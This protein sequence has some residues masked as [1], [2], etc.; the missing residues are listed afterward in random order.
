MAAVSAK[1]HHIDLSDNFLDFD[2]GRAFAAFLAENRTLEVLRVNNC[3]LGLKATEQIVEALTK[4]HEL[5]LR[6]FQAADND[7]CEE[8]MK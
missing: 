2:G 3:S 5:N 8:S 7:F 4:N 1:I 6:E